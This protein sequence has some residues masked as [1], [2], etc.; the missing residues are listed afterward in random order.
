MPGFE[1]GALM[2]IFRPKPVGGLRKNR[3]QNQQET[4]GKIEVQTSRKPSGKEI[5]KP[6]GDLRKRRRPNQQETFGY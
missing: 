6:G 5:S 4:F 2:K 1:N 3:R